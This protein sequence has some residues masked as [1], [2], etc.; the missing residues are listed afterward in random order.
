MLICLVFISGLVFLNV[1]Y[2]S[3]LVDPRLLDSTALK[4]PISSVQGEPVSGNEA[5]PIDSD[6]LEEGEI[7]SDEDEDET[8][9]N[10]DLR[11]CLLTLV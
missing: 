10:G 7:L 8:L 1:Q 5:S 9:L 3:I 11:G 6:E 4:A 2:I